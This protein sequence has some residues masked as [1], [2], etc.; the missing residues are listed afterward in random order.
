LQL[1][2]LHDPVG[3]ILDEPTT[4]LDRHQIVGIKKMI[5]EIGRRKDHS[6]FQRR[7]EEVKAVCDEF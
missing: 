5:R 6:A 1:A 7:Y 4:V 3:L 2:L